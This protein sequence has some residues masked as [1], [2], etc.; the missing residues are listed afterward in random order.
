[1]LRHTFS[2]A[3]FLF[4]P[5]EQCPKVCT[6]LGNTLHRHDGKYFTVHFRTILR[7]VDYWTASTVPAT[8][9]PYYAVGDHSMDCEATLLIIQSPS[10]TSCRWNRQGK[11]TLLM[12]TQWSLTS[13]PFQCGAALQYASARVAQWTVIQACAVRGRRRRCM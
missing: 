2:G 12:V 4:L 11:L 5:K 13:L 1:M 6:E 8:P 3:I 7:T 10:G 9:L